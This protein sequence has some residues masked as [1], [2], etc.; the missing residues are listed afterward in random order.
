MAERTPGR[1]ATDAERYLNQITRELARVERDNDIWRCMHGVVV[2]ENTLL[3][4]QAKEKDAELA[5][6]KALLCELPTAEK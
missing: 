5:R 1:R 4:R 6:L 2:A 3:Q